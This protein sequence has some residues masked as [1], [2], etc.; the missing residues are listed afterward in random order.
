[1]AR[2]PKFHRC[3]IE[4]ADLGP[5]LHDVLGPFGGGHDTYGFAALLEGRFITGA[6]AAGQ[7]ENDVDGGGSDPLDGL[8]IKIQIHGRRA[9]LGIAN[10]DMGDGGAGPSRVDDLVGDLLR[11]DRHVFAVGGHRAPAGYR[12][13]DHDLARHGNASRMAMLFQPDMRAIARCP[14]RFHP[15]PR[16]SGRKRRTRHV[17]PPVRW[18][19]S[20][21]RDTPRRRRR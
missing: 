4:T 6:H 12:T 19:R 10:M 20:R 13:G 8:R 17:R 15:R 16:G 21:H 11:R 7:V 14:F 3:D 5:Q 2:V 1:M 18:S 9:R